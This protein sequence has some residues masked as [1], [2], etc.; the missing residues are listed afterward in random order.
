MIS[1]Y[2]KS[3][4][5]VVLPPV[6]G[7]LR[8]PALRRRLEQADLRQL[9]APADDLGRVRDVLGSRGQVAAAGA[10]R[11]WGQT[12]DRPSRW[13]AA[14]DPV[15]LEPQLDHLRLRAATV[16]DLSSA[17]MRQ[18]FD[19][20][21]QEL[22]AGR[23]IGFVQVGTCGY[24]YSA[25]ELPTARLPASALDGFNPERHLPAGAAAH[26]RILGEIELALHDHAVNERRTAGGL[27]PVNS[28]WLWGGGALSDV[29]A[30]TL[31]ALFAAD[32]LLRGYWLSRGGRIGDW[33]GDAARAA[34]AAD[35]SFVAAAPG[36]FDAGDVLESWLANLL[37]SL[38]RGAVG[39][40]VLLF[41]DGI[42][43]RLSRRH[44][45]R[46]WRR[47]SDLLAGTAP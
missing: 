24:L 38:D 21:Q 20:L 34:A 30:E 2:A 32:P 41:R 37:A 29:P 39:R 8:S 22:G 11:F 46:F 1:S 44:R 40:L 42:C 16:A 4:A 9:D 12:G 7:R 5:F 26:R 10:L 47:H 28:L 27:A 17:D 19:Y 43:A 3:T 36:L 23:D 13:L 25:R 45:L 6:R 15:Y 33:P 35:G 14:A 18:L 31:P